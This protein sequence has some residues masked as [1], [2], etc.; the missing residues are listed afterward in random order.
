MNVPPEVGGAWDE[1]RSSYSAGAYTACEI[2][3]RKILMHLAVDV[4]NSKEGKNFVQ[5]INDL[6]AEGYIVKGLKVVIDQI[7]SRG[8]IANHELPASSQDQAD[9][10]MKIVEY[11]LHTI[12]ELPGMALKEA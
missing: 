5:Y 1:A 8:N 4:A 12:Y 10:T 3:C 9:Q 11:L 7:R 6:D 2:M